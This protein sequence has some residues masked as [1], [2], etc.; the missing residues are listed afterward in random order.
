[1]CNQNACSRMSKQGGK[2]LI[3]WHRV[4]LNRS[5]HCLIIWQVP[6]A[7]TAN[8]W[9]MLEK[10]MICLEPFERFA[11]KVSSAT[12]CT[13]DAVSSRWKPRL[14]LELNPWKIPF[15]QSLK[16]ALH[17]ERRTCVCILRVAGPTMQRQ[18][19]L[20]MLLYRCSFIKLFHS[21]WQTFNFNR[22]WNC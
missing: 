6:T 11:R 20:Y 5:K 22:T 13:A 7:L 10:T 12:A 3:T 15:E 17:P 14:T 8:Q 16:N 9:A 21:L 4:E 18:V 2:T 1:M 19:R